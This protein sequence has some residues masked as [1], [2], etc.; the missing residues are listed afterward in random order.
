MCQSGRISAVIYSGSSSCTLH[1]E[2]ASYANAAIER[3]P[4]VLQHRHYCLTTQKAVRIFV[5]RT[6]SYS[7]FDMVKMQAIAG[8]GCETISPKA[9]CKRERIRRECEL[10]TKFVAASSRILANLSQSTR[11]HRCTA[12]NIEADKAQIVSILREL[13]T[14]LGHVDDEYINSVT[15]PDKIAEGLA[16]EWKRTDDEQETRHLSAWD[17]HETSAQ[18]RHGRVHLLENINAAADSRQSV[19]MADC[20]ATFA[21]NVTADVRAVQHIGVKA[22]MRDK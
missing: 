11:E 1:G 16:A 18:P 17:I 4:T 14:M 19:T 9:S 6:Q 15:P 3:R 2:I 21:R 13:R 10:L 7:A 22:L 8:H 20:D 5:N 12:A